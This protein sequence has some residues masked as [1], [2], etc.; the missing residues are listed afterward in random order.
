[1][2]TRWVLEHHR[3]AEARPENATR[4]KHQPQTRQPT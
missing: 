3:P 4:Q 1:V 2:R